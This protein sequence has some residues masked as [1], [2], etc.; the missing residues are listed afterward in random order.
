MA[1]AS[2][3]RV[4]KKLREKA[5]AATAVAD[6]MESKL[7]N[8]VI[9]LGIDEML[10]YK[11]LAMITAVQKHEAEKATVQAKID[12]A[13]RDKKRVIN[14]ILESHKERLQGK[15]KMETVSFDD[16]TAIFSLKESEENEGKES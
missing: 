7:S 10:K 16:G 5:A 6:S 9:E 15:Y 2:T 1:K 3:K 4:A 13:E 14:E 11:L 8:G 12:E